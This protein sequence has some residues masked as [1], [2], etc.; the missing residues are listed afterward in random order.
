MHQATRFESKWFEVPGITPPG[1]TP[2]DSATHNYYSINSSWV[3]GRAK[4]SKDLVRIRGSM[5]LSDIDLLH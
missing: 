4:E 1:I 2:P 5:G 3:R